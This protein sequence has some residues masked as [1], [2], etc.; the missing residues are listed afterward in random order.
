MKSWLR[1]CCACFDVSGTY[2]LLIFSEHKLFFATLDVKLSLLKV[3]I[4][5]G[6]Y[7]LIA[8]STEDI[9]AA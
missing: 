5:L 2:V 7:T 1:H 3:V 9:L 4:V 8:L 6:R